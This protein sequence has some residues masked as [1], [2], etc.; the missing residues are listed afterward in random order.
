MSTDSKTEPDWAAAIALRRRDCIGYAI[1]GFLAFLAA[2][3]SG[4]GLTELGSDRLRS[5][6]IVISALTSIIGI[7]F[8]FESEKSLMAKRE[9]VLR[10]LTKR[11]SASPLAHFL[12]ATAIGAIY[13]VAF[14]CFYLS[15]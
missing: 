8:S 3:L 7:V 9:E 4:P 6:M 13:S 5:T 10:P 1:V 2:L 15:A 12:G 14:Y 11:K